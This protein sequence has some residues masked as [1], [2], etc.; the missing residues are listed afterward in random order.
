MAIASGTVAFA[1]QLDI[2]GNYIL[3]DHGWGVYSGYAHFS[4]INVAQGQTIARGQLL[5]LSGNTGRSN[6]PH[7]H[8]EISVQGEW[9]DGDAFIH[10]WLPT[11]P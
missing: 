4:Q 7:L 11:A 5:G 9:V 2:R 8:W 6:G 3:I 10:M 1:G